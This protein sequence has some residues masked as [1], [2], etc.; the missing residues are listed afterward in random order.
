MSGFTPFEVYSTVFERLPQ[1][2]LFV[3]AFVFLSFFP[4][5]GIEFQPQFA[6]ITGDPGK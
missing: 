3:V 1:M 6:V 2:Q 5:Q 4:V